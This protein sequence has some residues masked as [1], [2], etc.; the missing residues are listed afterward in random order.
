MGRAYPREALLSRLL[1]LGYARDEDY[2]VLGEVVELGEVRLEFFGDELERLVVRGRKG[3]ATSFCPSRG[4]RRAS[5]PRRSS[6]SL[7]PS[8]W[9][10]PPS[11]PRPF[12]PSS[13]EGPGWPWAAGWSSP[14]ELGARPLPPYRGSLKALEKDLARWL[15]EGKRV[16]LFVGHARTLEYLKRRLQAFSPLILDRF[17]GP[18]GRLALLPGDFEGGA[19]WGEWVLLTEALVFATGGCGPGSG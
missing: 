1:K 14:L 4:R 16:H 18:K 19:E 12:G 7:A 13:R 10:P 11:P 17:P 5:P 3:G 9:T 2:R 6:T 8:T 15:A